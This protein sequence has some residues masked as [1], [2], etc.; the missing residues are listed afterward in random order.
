MVVETLDDACTDVV[1]DWD[2]LDDVCS[3]VNIVE[4]DMLCVVI[5]CVV[6]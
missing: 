6:A 1:M 5:A 2:E 3:A 4:T